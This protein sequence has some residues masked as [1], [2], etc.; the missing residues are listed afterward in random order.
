[1]EYQ[2]LLIKALFNTSLELVDSKA[3]ESSTNDAITV[4]HNNYIE[5]GIRALS[6][7]FASVYGFMDEADFRKLATAYIHAH[8]KTSFDWADFG[9]HFSR[10]MFDI[11]ALAGMPFLPE[12]AELDWRLSY[13]ER[14]S[15]KQFDGASFSLLQT[16]STDELRFVAAPGLQL[17]NAFFPLNELYH[18]IHEVD[19][20]SPEVATDAGNA[21]NSG[22]H[23]NKLINSAINLPEQRSIVLWRE[24]YKGLFEYVDEASMNAFKSLLNGSSISGVLSHFGDD[25]NAMTNWLQQHIQTKKIYA[26]VENN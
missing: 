20:G 4:Y 17:M 9:E 6:I 19:V 16:H 15:N 13:I 14:A 22:A 21:E 26:V 23:V 12:L 11:E 7:S 10:F 25:Q 3:S 18:L 5:S 2:S 1:M 24:D 8:P